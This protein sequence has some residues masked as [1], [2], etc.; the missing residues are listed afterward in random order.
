MT[1]RIVAGI[2]ALTLA[3]GT[4]ALPHEMFEN[5]AITAS[6]YTEKEL[7]YGDFKY[8]ILAI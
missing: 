8:E 4:V 6:A 1:K 7:T 2:L 5:V 3:M